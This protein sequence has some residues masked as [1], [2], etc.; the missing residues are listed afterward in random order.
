VLAE[1]E[2]RAAVLARLTDDDYRV[3]Q[4]TMRALLPLLNQRTDLA[5]PTLPWLAGTGDEDYRRYGSSPVT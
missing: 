5:S 1:D 3:R 4:A 2:V